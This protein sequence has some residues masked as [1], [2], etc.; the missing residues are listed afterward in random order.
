MGRITGL[1]DIHQIPP[2]VLQLYQAVLQLVEE[3]A[4]V[5]NIRVSTITE[6]AGIGKGTAYEYFDSKEEIVACAVVYR[7]AILREWLQSKL[8]KRESFAEQLD[9]L[10]EEICKRNCEM[11]GLLQLIHILTDHSELSRLIY[12]KMESKAFEPYMPIALFRNVIDMGIRKGELRSDLPPDYQVYTLLSHLMAYMLAIHTE[13]NLHIEV[14]QMRDLVYQE[15]LKEL[16]EKN[17]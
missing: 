17:R 5:G 15:L 16:C 2:K 3:G 7:M 4:D 1:E 14:E 12:Q 10:L 13:Q 9:F 11:N 8:E 6:R